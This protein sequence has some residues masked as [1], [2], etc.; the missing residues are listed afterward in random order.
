M[1]LEELNDQWVREKVNDGNPL[2]R[3]TFNRHR[4]AIL[5]M[6]GVVLECDVRNHYRYY[7]ANPEVFDD[8]RSDGPSPRSLLVVCSPIVPH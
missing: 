2:S 6:Y 4:D 3:T 8:D 7:I 5:D 1:T